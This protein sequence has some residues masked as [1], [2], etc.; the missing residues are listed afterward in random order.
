M[1]GVEKKVKD[2][3]TGKGSKGKGG[4]KKGKGTGGKGGSPVEKAAKKLLK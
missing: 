2:A 3:V 4:G 1:A